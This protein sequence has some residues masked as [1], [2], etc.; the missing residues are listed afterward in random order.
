[1]IEMKK[2]I[3][4]DVDSLLQFDFF[5]VFYPELGGSSLDSPHGFVVEYGINKDVELGMFL[6]LRSL[7]WME[8]VMNFNLNGV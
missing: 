8:S 5:V 1:M 3:Y 2:L 7:L 6:K 4:N